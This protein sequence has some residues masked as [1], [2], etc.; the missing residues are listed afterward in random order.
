MTKSLKKVLKIYSKSEFTQKSTQ[1]ESLLKKSSWKSERRVFSILFY[2]FFYIFLHCISY[3]TICEGG[4]STVGPCLVKLYPTPPSIITLGAHPSWL[5]YCTWKLAFGHIHT[6]AGCRASDPR[7]NRI[8]RCSSSLA[9]SGYNR[10]WTDIT[11][12]WHVLIES[13]N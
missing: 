4:G 7:P 13:I 12:H 3:S 11:P 2:F 6:Q 5:V 9:A 8:L 1:K 10:P